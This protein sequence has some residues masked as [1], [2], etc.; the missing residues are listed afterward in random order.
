[1]NEAF[2][3]AFQFRN[4]PNLYESPHRNATSVPVIR[5]LSA[6]TFST[7]PDPPSVT[8]RSLSYIVPSKVQEILSAGGTVN[9]GS[10]GFPS[11]FSS[12]YSV[13]T[14]VMESVYISTSDDF[15]YRIWD[16]GRSVNNLI[17]WEG[18]DAGDPSANAAS[19][20]WVGS[21]TV[22]WISVDEAAVLLNVSVTELTPAKFKDEYA[23]A[24]DRTHT[25]APTPSPTSG[26][27]RRTLCVTVFGMMTT[28]MTM[29]MMC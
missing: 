16:D 1:M 19:S 23:A 8:A 10:G 11:L 13:Q 7:P 5:W 25:P 17:A 12:S 24:W 9:T 27:E 26:A 29:M 15:V 28:M 18:D 21:G 20:A 2:G 4:G 22:A 6:A 14:N 3:Q